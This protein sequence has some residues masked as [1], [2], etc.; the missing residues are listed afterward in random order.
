MKNESL[1]IGCGWVL[2][3]AAPSLTITLK[4]FCASML[5]HAHTRA[6]TDWVSDHIPE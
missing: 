5:A 1:K 3:P 6:Y 4:H 2:C